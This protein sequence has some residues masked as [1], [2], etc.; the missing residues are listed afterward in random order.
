MTRPL[1]VRSRAEADLDEAFGWYEAQVPGL[2]EA[3]L[4]SVTA[5]F[6]R[7]ARHA[8]A[9]PQVQGQVRRAALRRFPYGVFYVVREDRIDVLA[10]YHGRRR[11][12]VFDP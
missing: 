2:G 1:T 11:P 5:C 8:E 3:F 4:R 9:Y 12:R 6:V 7:I 10:V